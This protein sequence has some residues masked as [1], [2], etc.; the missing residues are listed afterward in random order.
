V[1]QKEKN[2]AEKAEQVRANNLKK[3]NEMTL[4]IEHAELENKSR[5]DDLFDEKKKMEEQFEKNIQT[6]KENHKNEMERR[7]QEY[8]EKMEADQ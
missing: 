7:R 6:M 5:Y 3:I 4:E 2:R 1:K 8:A